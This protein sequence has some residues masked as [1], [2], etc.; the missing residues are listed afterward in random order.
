MRGLVAVR[1]EEEKEDQRKRSKHCERLRKAMA[2]VDAMRLREIRMPVMGFGFHGPRR[3][4]CFLLRAVRVRSMVTLT[5]MIFMR[6]RFVIVGALNVAIAWTTAN[7]AGVQ[8]IL[9]RAAEPRSASVQT[10]SQPCPRGALYLATVADL[11]GASGVAFRGN[12]LFVATPEILPT[13]GDATENRRS[14][15]VTVDWT[16][17]KMMA[18]RLPGPEG[19]VEGDEPENRG[20]AVQPLKIEASCAVDVATS[21]DGDV[22]VVDLAGAVLRGGVRVGE[23]VLEAP[24]AVTCDGAR[25]LVADTRLRAVVVFDG[26]GREVDRLGVGTLIEPAGLAVGRTGDLFVAD[27]LANCLW[28]F[29]RTGEQFNKSPER[30]GTRGSGPGQFSAPRDVAVIPAGGG[31]GCLLIADELNH[32]LQVLDADGKPQGFFGMHAL[33]P[34]QGDGRIHYPRAVA[35]APD[36]VTIAVAEAFEDRVQLLRLKAEEDPVD[37]TAGSLEYISSHFGAESG[38]GADLLAVV[39][40][41]TQSI[42]LLD[43]RS[44]PPLHISIVGG[45]GA[46]PGRFGEISALAIDPSDARIYVADRVRQRLDV[47]VADWE[48]DGPQKLDL[49]IPRL[50]RSLALSRCIKAELPVPERYAL[51]VPDVVDMMVGTPA[52]GPEKLLLLDRANMGVIETDVRL[53]PGKFTPL[54]REARLPEEFAR[55]A[56]GALFVADPVAGAVFELPAGSKPEANSWIMHRALGGIALVRPA[57][58]A[59]PDGLI[60]VADAARDACV[61]WDGSAAR[62]V[63]ERGGLDEQFFDPASIVGTDLGWIVIDRGNHRFQRFGT[64]NDDPFAWNMTGGLGRFFDRKRRG[65]PGFVSPST[66]PPSSPTVAPSAGTAKNGEPVTSERANGGS[67]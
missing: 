25:T 1:G 34:R 41:E 10:V 48:K 26:D 3:V 54:P 49:F 59:C 63:G 17:V 36:G 55:R 38:A 43:A 33:V 62:I 67:Q 57:G 14:Q 61:V 51:R 53:A 50:A 23:G 13:G 60:V 15:L 58:I 18:G 64:K 46:L 56:D 45:S 24:I 19:I 40:V 66:I 29:R 9:T 20:L 30:I 39:D 65:S 6:P 27:R 4:A 8:P 16:P 35:V 42:A 21:P 7:G 2:P 5:N 52:G 12:E 37:P 32:R 31:A 28:R 22:V 44:T 47:L 11:R